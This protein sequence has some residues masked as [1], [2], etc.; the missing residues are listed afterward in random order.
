V[1]PRNAA[2]IRNRAR[3]AAVVAAAHDCRSGRPGRL[4]EA[5][6]CCAAARIRPCCR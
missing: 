2:V 6:A 4:A 5:D 1:P 3:A